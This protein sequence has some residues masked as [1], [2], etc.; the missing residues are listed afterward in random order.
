MDCRPLRLLLEWHAIYQSQ[1]GGLRNKTFRWWVTGGNDWW[2]MNELVIFFFIQ[3]SREN[4]STM[5]SGP[6][7]V[8]LPTLNRDKEQGSHIFLG[9]AQIS[10]SSLPRRIEAVPRGKGPYYCGW[11][12]CNTCF[13]SC[14]HHKKRIAWNQILRLGF[15]VEFLQ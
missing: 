8:Q 5:D 14:M 1:K 7:H 15:E 6:Q 3:E 11:P 2:V 4:H 12:Y 13:I 10:H 9:S